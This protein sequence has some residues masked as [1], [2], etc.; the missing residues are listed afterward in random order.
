[1][2]K[3]V[4]EL[5]KEFDDCL[6]DVLSGN[7]KSKENN[8]FK[9]LDEIENLLNKETSNESIDK[10]ENDIKLKTELIQKHKNIIQYCKSE[11]K[12]YLTKMG[13]N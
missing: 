13:E 8:F 5:N 3:L 6:S 1:M 12:D 11:I 10:I 9:K 2:H 4:E 7:Q